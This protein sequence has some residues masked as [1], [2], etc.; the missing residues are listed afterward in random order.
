MT[1][2][3]IE[4]VYDIPAASTRRHT[5]Y[6]ISSVKTPSPIETPVNMEEQR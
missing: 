4:N 5:L 2:D 1:S 3:E 6:P